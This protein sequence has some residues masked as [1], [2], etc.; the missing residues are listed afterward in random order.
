MIFMIYQI[1]IIYHLSWLIAC[2]KMVNHAVFDSGGGWC[3]GSRLHSQPFPPSISLH[4]TLSIHH[5]STVLKLQVFFRLKYNCCVEKKKPYILFKLSFILWCINYH[6]SDLQRCTSYNPVTIYQAFIPVTMYKVF[7]LHFV[8]IPYVSTGVRI[9]AYTNLY[10]VLFGSSTIG[11]KLLIKGLS[12]LSLQPLPWNNGWFYSAVS[13]FICYKHIE[14]Y[15]C[16]MHA[17]KVVFVIHQFM[18]C[19]SIL[20]WPKLFPSMALWLPK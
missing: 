12:R 19:L 8:F 4:C 16:S 18:G 13:T 20:L 14:V 2:F 17:C 11:P 15:V 5:Y 3:V 7:I 9:H 6:L 1:V 10:R